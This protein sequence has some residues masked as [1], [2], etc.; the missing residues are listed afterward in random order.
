VQQASSAKTQVSQISKNNVASS[1]GGHIALPLHGVTPAP[2]PCA[3]AR[4]QELVSKHLRSQLIRSA[5]DA[6][7]QNSRDDRDFWYHKQI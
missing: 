6:N 5:A 7:A 2:S 3:V 1:L 4:M